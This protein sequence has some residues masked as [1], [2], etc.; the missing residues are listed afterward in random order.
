MAGMDFANI[1]WDTVATQACGPGTHWN[2]R[3]CV[4]DAGGPHGPGGPPRVAPAAPDLSGIDF[5][6]LAAQYPDI[7]GGPGPT[8]AAEIS[9]Y[10][11]DSTKWGQYSEGFN[12]APAA[13]AAP[14]A[15]PVDWYEQQGI[16]S[17]GISDDEQAWLDAAIAGGSFQGD[18]GE[19]PFDQTVLTEDWD[20]DAVYTQQMVDD[21]R[22]QERIDFA[23]S[24]LQQGHTVADIEQFLGM[25]SLLTSDEL[26]TVQGERLDSFEGV[27]SDQWFDFLEGE[28]VEVL[29]EHRSTLPWVDSPEFAAKYGNPTSAG[30]GA[31]DGA[32]DGAGG[33]GG[34]GGDPA[35]GDT[36]AG[37]P[38]YVAAQVDEI[39][40]INARLKSITDAHKKLLAS[41][42]GEIDA[43]EEALTLA[44]S[45]IY[46]AQYGVVGPDGEVLTP[47]EMDRLLSTFETRRKTTKSNR[48]AD[49]A[50]ILSIMTDEG[51][52]AGLAESELDMI[53]AIHGDSIDAQY[54]YIESL[55]RIG[56]MSHD[57]RTSMIGNMIGS[58]KLQ[59]RDTVVEMLMAEEVN[60]ADHVA[61]AQQDAL[62]ADTIASLFP[63]MSEDQVYGLMRSGMADLLQLPADKE[64]GMIE[65]GEWAGYTSGEKT[66][67]LVN[68]GWTQNADGTFVAPADDAEDAE[69]T[70]KK[71]LPDGVTPFE[72][73]PNEYFQMTGV[74]MFA[75]GEDPADDLGS[76]RADVGV[77][78]DM[79]YGDWLDGQIAAGNLTVDGASTGSV[80]QG[81][82]FPA[83]DG[84]VNINWV[85]YPA[86]FD[87]P[88]TPKED[89]EDEGKVLSKV[90]P[91]GSTW[92]GTA[93]QYY[94][95]HGDYI[96]AEEEKA[97]DP[98]DPFE[99][100][101]TGVPESFLGGASPPVGAEIKDGELWMT[102]DGYS[103]FVDEMNYEEPTVATHG[104]DAG[105]SLDIAVNDM[106]SP[107]YYNGILRPFAIEWNK[108]LKEEDG[109]EYGYEDF[110][111]LT[112]AAIRS[113]STLYVTEAKIIAH[114]DNRIVYGH[115]GG[116][117]NV[118]KATPGHGAGA[119]APAGKPFFAAVPVANGRI[120]MIYA[121][122]AQAVKDAAKQAYPDKR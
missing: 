108:H 8:V 104:V 32:G 17:P 29:D 112:D 99:R 54:D 13:P 66:N 15:A 24:L 82:V 117:R 71:T 47:G 109:D 53:Q 60:T 50:E 57:E 63:N 39:N 4:P 107:N 105:V 10:N 91:D 7:F 62:R 55:W 113:L 61:A 21:P 116:A 12:A 95:E 37:V 80:T 122:S 77:L 40:I 103:K 97:E 120:A 27:G 44:E 119:E 115:E 118:S 87:V 98:Y 90:M 64:I 18:L 2:G 48:T 52:P 93:Q 19:V 58:Y 3:E 23:E 96:F 45:E 83:S 110:G 86:A 38:T 42:I 89:P 56:K 88:I 92:T 51:V 41:G 35:G 67:V 72:G 49:R 84:Y 74:R 9:P 78:R 31:G 102:P 85:D 36:P 16:V 30:N 68:A 33:A 106:A 70:Y 114:M 43:I 25:E 5:A 76:F 59:L 22:L 69:K 20:P 1:D 73:T 14:A 6:G 46:E 100:F 34:A 81:N 11:E 26:G 28:G 65:A 79:G 101:N 121:S 75:P 111:A 94:D